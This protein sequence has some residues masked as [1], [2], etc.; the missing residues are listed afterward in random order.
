M[1]LVCALLLTVLLL[2]LHQVESHTCVDFERNLSQHLSKVTECFSIHISPVSLCGW[3]VEP[4]NELQLVLSDTSALTP[5]G[6]RCSDQM[7][8]SDK[9]TMDLIQF[10]ADFW[11][12]SFCPHCLH[13]DSSAEKDDWLDKLKR[14]T[15]WPTLSP[16][17]FATSHRNTDMTAYNLAVYNN[18][19]ARF[20]ELLNVTLDCFTQHIGNLSE[21]I[22][23]TL[24]FPDVHY[25][26]IDRS[27]CRDCYAVY[28]ELLDMYNEKLARLNVEHG[29]FEVVDYNK[30]TNY[31]FAVCSDIQYAL[32]RTQWAWS[33]LISCRDS[34]TH[35]PQVL[36]PLLVCLVAMTLFHALS[37]TV[38]RRPIHM[39][40]YRP[41]R[42]EPRLRSSVTCPHS[43]T[44]TQRGRLSCVPS[45]GSLA[46]TS[47][48]QNGSTEFFVRSNFPLNT[49]Q[50]SVA[51]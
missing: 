23:D 50:P 40:I 39:L 16:S 12:R 8:F 42:V 6:E 1:P 18:E 36:L 22:L 7:V 14:L 30:Y 26:K 29:G 33:Y 20:F 47:L 5:S 9:A 19:T 38:C 17:R 32:N 34:E 51:S 41:V 28:Q 3:C 25:L 49:G 15:D 35:I 45:Y 46:S 27:A 13:N 44:P 37:Y 24:S 4:L 2:E 21:S 43:N 31:R 10:I 48:Q 11:N